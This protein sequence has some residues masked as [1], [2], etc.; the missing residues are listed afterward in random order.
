[1]TSSDSPVD[2]RFTDTAHGQLTNLE[3]ETQERIKDKLRS[4]REQP[5]RHIER[6]RG[7]DYYKVRVGDYRVLI[8]WAENENVRSRPPGVD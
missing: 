5:L 1:M 6:L 8:D 3:Q 2:V 7:Y 4:V